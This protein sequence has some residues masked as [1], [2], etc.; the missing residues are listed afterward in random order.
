MKKGGSTMANTISSKKLLAILQASRSISKTEF[1]KR[2]G[3][4]TPTLYAWIK[5]NRDGIADY[6]TED[7]I[8]PEIFEVEPWSAYKDDNAM[9]RQRLQAEVDDLNEDMVRADEQIAALQSEVEK[10]QIKVDAMQQTID[11]LNGQISAKD[12]QINALLVSLNLQMKALPQPKKHWWQRR[13]R[14]DENA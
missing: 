12:Q 4:S 8:S 11:F 5:K 7:G 2:I 3:V 9:E 1:A 14:D 10:M 13:Q 6:V